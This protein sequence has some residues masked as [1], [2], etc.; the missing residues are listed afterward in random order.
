[1]SVG[2]KFPTDEE[3]FASAGTVFPFTAFKINSGDRCRFEIGDSSVAMV[4]VVFSQTL[5][6]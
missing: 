4:L 1:M 5:S 6:L 3:S 2:T